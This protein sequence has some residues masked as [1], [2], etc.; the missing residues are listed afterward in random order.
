MLCA[1]CEKDN[2]GVHGGKG[3]TKEE[4]ERESVKNLGVGEK[5]VEGGES[6]MQGD[7]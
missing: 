6:E 7:I 3:D 4:T 2:T 1:G 5:F